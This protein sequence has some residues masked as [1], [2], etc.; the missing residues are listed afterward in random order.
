MFDVCPDVLDRIQVGRVGG[1]QEDRRPLPLGDTQA[2]SSS[3]SAVFG[4]DTSSP[5]K[6][7][8]W[9]T[10]GGRARTRPEL[11]RAAVATRLFPDPDVQPAPDS[12]PRRD[13]E[14][15]VAWR[16]GEGCVEAGYLRF[17]QGFHDAGVAGAEGFEEAVE[18]A[19][20]AG[21]EYVVRRLPGREEG[22]N[23]QGGVSSSATSSSRRSP[24][25]PNSN[26]SLSAG[27]AAPH[28]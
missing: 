19:V 22:G 1:Q 6:G 20:A 24:C 13:Q 27:N 18:V 16:L 21:G 7:G 2:T 10:V 23:D 5:V 28:S 9:S 8:A 14:P 26:D 25:S 3:A 15:A 4:K 11:F 17:Q 12:S